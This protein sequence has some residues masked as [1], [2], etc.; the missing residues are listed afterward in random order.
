[1]GEN[2]K[3]PWVRGSLNWYNILNMKGM[4]EYELPTN[5]IYSMVLDHEQMFSSYTIV[6]VT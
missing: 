1:M 4:V 3:F 5:N 2:H 6:K